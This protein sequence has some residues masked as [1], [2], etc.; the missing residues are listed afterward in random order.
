MRYSLRLYAGIVQQSIVRERLMA[1]LAGPFG[2]LAL[3][4]TALG[5]AG[6]FSY[7]VAQR[8]REIGIRLALGAT[9]RGVMARVLNEAFA[10]VAAGLCGGLLVTAAASRAFRS[11]LFGVQPF[12]P[13]SLAAAC[14][15]LACA[16]GAA[17]YVP[18]RRAAA[19]DPVSSLRHE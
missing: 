3:A 2:V 9:R 13:L 14:A 7:A 18:A 11:L 5:L 4:L 6:V 1:A 19:V 15:L 16:A 10:T 17:A 12:D 8:T